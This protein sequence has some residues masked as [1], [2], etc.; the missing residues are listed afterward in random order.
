MA[1]IETVRLRVKIT[2]LKKGAVPVGFK[3]TPL[4]D[5]DT[6]FAEY[7]CRKFITGFI[8]SHFVVSVEDGKLIFDSKLDDGYFWAVEVTKDVENELR[9][10]I[11]HKV[12]GHEPHILLPL[13]IN[14]DSTGF[15]FFS[16]AGIKTLLADVTDE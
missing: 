11:P 3:A 16:E 8:A 2:P 7:F 5:G 13:Q 10:V 14:N 15:K 1:E 4:W 12:Y 6:F 9:V